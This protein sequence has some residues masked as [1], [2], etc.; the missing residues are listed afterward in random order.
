MDG[1]LKME[2]MSCG[3]SS[4]PCRKRHA[5]ETNRESIAMNTNDKGI[6][7]TFCNS[8]T[9]DDCLHGFMGAG[10][11][12][13]IGTDNWCTQVNLCLQG[14]VSSIEEIHCQACEWKQWK[15]MSRQN[16][17]QCLHNCQTDAPCVGCLAHPEFALIA[18]PPLEGEVHIQ[19]CRKHEIDP[20]GPFG[21]WHFV[22]NCPL[23]LQIHENKDMNF[24]CNKSGCHGIIQC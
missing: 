2:C 5:I 23:A 11:S 7:C 18:C 8:F 15:P 4:I 24:Q 16:H 21:A 12:Q 6:S 3:E 13:C 1:I 10:C 22:I 19:G 20:C 9:C 17:A 14:E